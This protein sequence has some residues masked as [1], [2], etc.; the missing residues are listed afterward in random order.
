MSAK[1][2]WHNPH[3]NHAYPY[4]HSQ[5]ASFVGWCLMHADIICTKNTTISMLQRLRDDAA[6]TAEALR[7]K[8]PAYKGFYKEVRLLNH[9]IER[10]RNN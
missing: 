8:I 3:N 10:I 1:L 5:N 6:V 2:H 9:L 7:G 4:W